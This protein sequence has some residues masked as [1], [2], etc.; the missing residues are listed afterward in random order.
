MFDGV[1]R[2]S[3]KLQSGGMLLIHKLIAL[4]EGGT[5][6]TG[7]SPNEFHTSGFGGNFC[8]YV[9]PAYRLYIMR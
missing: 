4:Y 8:T 9:C 2:I 1:I 7:V 3:L 5:L 6:V